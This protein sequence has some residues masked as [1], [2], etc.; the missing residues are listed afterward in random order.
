M[1]GAAAEAAYVTAP[2]SLKV[3]KLA[4]SATMARFVIPAD[5]AGMPCEWTTYGCDADVVAGLVTTTTTLDTASA[6]DGSG[7]ITPNAATGRKL[8]D[9]VS[10]YWVM[11][12]IDD[13]T[14]HII[15]DASASGYLEI[16]ISGGG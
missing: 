13:R 12:A 15:V 16:A 2:R 10:R 6:V 4:I 1:S 14:T 3:L 11:P 5:F 7:V 9:G 8:K